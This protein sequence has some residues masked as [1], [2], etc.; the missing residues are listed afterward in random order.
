LGR[1]AI[2]HLVAVSMDAGLFRPQILALLWERDEAIRRRARE[3]PR[4]DVLEDRDLEVLAEIRIGVDAQLA[5][6]D[7]RLRKGGA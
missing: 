3:H 1:K 5:A 2:A 4:T 7:A 6:V